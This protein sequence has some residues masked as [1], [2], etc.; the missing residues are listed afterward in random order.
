MSP[1]NESSF[2]ELRALHRSMNPLNEA[3]FPDKSSADTEAAGS[4]E[5]LRALYLSM[6]PL[7]EAQLPDESSADTEEISIETLQSLQRQCIAKIE[8]EPDLQL[9]E[10]LLKFVRIMNYPIGVESNREFYSPQAHLIR[11]GLKEAL[12][13]ILRYDFAWFDSYRGHYE[14]TFKHRARF[15]IGLLSKRNSIKP[16]NA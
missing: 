7:N 3:Q 2:E 6:S 5:E 16:N 14:E 1:L 15:V 10:W 11:K 4:N 13:A 12:Q 8:Q 9:K